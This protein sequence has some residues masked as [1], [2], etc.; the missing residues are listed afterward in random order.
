[1][2]LGTRARTA[3]ALTAMLLTTA[4]V[5]V[6]ADLVIT[7]TPGNDT[8]TGT[9]EAE[10]IYGRAGNDTINA[11]GG[12][13]DLDGG[14]GSDIL[15]GGDGRDAVSYAGAAGAGVQVAIDGVASDGFP[16]E[17]DKIGTDVEDIYGTDGDDKITGSP[18]A[19][20]IDGGGGTDLLDGGPGPDVVFGGEGEDTIMAR[21]G[22]VDRIECGGGRDSVT[23][24]LGDVV[25]G[26]CENVAKPQVTIRPG[27]T[28]NAKKGGK[29]I[30][31]SS[32]VSKSNVRIIC[33]TCKKNSQKT[34]V[35]AKSVSLSKGNV[36]V[37]P[38]KE[39]IKGKTIELGVRAPDSAPTCIRF[40]VKNNFSYTSDRKTPCTSAAKDV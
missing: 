8:L 22:E 9:A 29:K 32:I 33:I 7:G 24:D 30:I 28:L 26:D 31:I 27:L 39:H 38:W 15:N 35:D 13:D 34:V 36:A 1:M 23:V 5:A 2:H 20:T 25:A 4:S 17:D 12:D 14:S 37:F 18:A 10:A 19:N 6:A 16:G 21:D 3:L 11:G 40:K